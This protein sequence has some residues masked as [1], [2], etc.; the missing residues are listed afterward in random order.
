M[1]RVKMTR[2]DQMIN[3]LKNHSIISIVI[4]IV[5]VIIFLAKFKD[6]LQSLFTQPDKRTQIF[7]QKIEKSPGSIQAGRDVI[8]KVEP[9]IPPA[10]PPIARFPFDLQVHNAKERIRYLSQEYLKTDTMS[11]VEVKGAYG[12]NVLDNPQLYD[13]DKV[14]SELETQGYIKILRRQENNIEFKVLGMLIPPPEIKIS[15]PKHGDKVS[16]ISQV[17]V[18]ISGKLSEGQ[19]I[20][21]VVNPS[22]TPN[23]YWPQGRIDPLKN[24]LSLPAWFGKEK[25]DIGYQFDIVVIL[26]D[27]KENMYYDDYLE[28]GKKTG[29]YPG[30]PLPTSTRVIDKITVTRR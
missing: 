7:Q 25:E 10:T 6:A 5:I 9:N 27:E 18:D 17:G 30:I 12:D 15:S 11:L 19:Y 21:V 13:W 8:I 14:M 16:V 4:V 22:L 2:V 3:W 24:K 20:W 28:R 1:V 26:V 29:N 23:E